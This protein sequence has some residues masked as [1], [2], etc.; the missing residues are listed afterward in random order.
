VEQLGGEVVACAFLIELGFLPGRA[1]LAPHAVHALIT[2]GS[3]DE[4]AGA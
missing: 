2:E 3:E 1:T 4:A